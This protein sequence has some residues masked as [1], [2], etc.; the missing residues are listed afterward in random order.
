MFKTLLFHFFRILQCQN[1]WPMSSFFDSYSKSFQKIR[2]A[3]ETIVNIMDQTID[4]LETFSRQVNI[5]LKGLSKDHSD[6]KRKERK[7]SVEKRLESIKS[8][9]RQDFT[10]LEPNFSAAWNFLHNNY[11]KSNHSLQEFN[12]ELQNDFIPQLKYVRNL[13]ESKMLEIDTNI[14]QAVKNLSEAEE[15]ARMADDKYR[16]HCETI[17][18]AKEKLNEEEVI[19]N[20]KLMAKFQK[21][22]NDAVSLF[23]DLQKNAID[24][25]DEVNEQKMNYLR[26]MELSLTLFEQSDCQREESFKKMLFNFIAPLEKLA[27]N[28]ITTAEDLSKSLSASHDDI[29]DPLFELKD[30]KLTNVTYEP[31]KLPFDILEFISPQKIFEAD[32]SNFCAFV[33]KDYTATKTGELSL[34]AGEKVVVLDDKN[35]MWKVQNKASKRGLAPSNVFKKIP[36]TVRYLYTVVSDYQAQDPKDLSVKKGDMVMSVNRK[37]NYTVCLDTYFQKGKIPS[38]NLELC[39]K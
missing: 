31:Q 26:E 25:I 29:P 12:N 32:L 14:T 9:S 24:L 15:A 13:Y 39:K 37:G 21:I 36:E 6:S 2:K 28:L 11:F 5:L 10:D 30:V 22:F 20:E 35:D 23:P 4:K 18:N 16:E 34:S 33:T 17:E 3:K 38:I 19:S 7:P 8:S 1:F 27:E